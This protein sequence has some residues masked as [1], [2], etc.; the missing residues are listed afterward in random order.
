MEPGKPGQKRPEP[1]VWNWHV[2]I[3]YVVGG[4]LFALALQWLWLSYQ[5][6][7]SVSYTEFQ[8]M[9]AD[10]KIAE[11]TV[12][13][14]TMRGRLNEPLP[15]G[16]RDVTTVRVDPALA[17][18]LHAHGAEVVGEAPPGALVQMLSW[19]APLMLFYIV[20]MF[21]FRRMSGGQ[22][23]GGLMSIGKSRAKVYLE[24]DTKVTYADV[25][26]VDEAKAE[27]QEVVAFLRSPQSYGRLGGRSPK[28]VLL[29]GPPGTGKTL[30]ARATAGEAGVPFFS[31]SGAEF[32]EMSWAWV[33]RACATCSPRHVR[34]HPASSSSTS[35][36]RSA[37]RAPA[38]ASSAAATTRR[39]RRSTSCW[40]SSTASIRASASFCLPRPTGRKS[41]TPRCCG[42]AGSIARCWS[43]G[44]TAKGA[45]RSWT[46]T[47]ARYGWHRVWTSTSWPG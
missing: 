29:V 43:T 42:R 31:I 24:T 14:S 18:Q 25:A 2:A 46:C 11:V 34:P 30:L 37:A 1:D 32:V 17:D 5:P 19:L 41:S 21:A 40:P 15:G 22:G 13:P 28:G 9:V 38:A 7:Q 44:P 6:T 20:W 33:P 35:S 12:S 4:L 45:G 26:G 39:S 23:I 36:T 3:T 16:Q 27:L 47:R 10:G 8:K